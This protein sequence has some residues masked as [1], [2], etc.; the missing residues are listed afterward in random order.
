MS[1]GFLQQALETWGL[2]VYIFPCGLW[3][4]FLGRKEKIINKTQQEEKAEVK[5]Q[6]NKVFGWQDCT[7][8]LTKS[9]DI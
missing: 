3:G 7:I 8:V 9:F 2:P 6:W 4:N 1:C 5:I